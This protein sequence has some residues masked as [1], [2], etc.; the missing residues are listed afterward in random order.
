MSKGAVLNCTRWVMGV[1]PPPPGNVREGMGFLEYRDKTRQERQTCGV[2]P[3][4]NHW[5]T[6]EP[7]LCLLLIHYVQQ[8]TLQKYTFSSKGTATNLILPVLATTQRPE[9]LLFRTPQSQGHSIGY[10]SHYLSCPYTLRWRSMTA[11]QLMT[12]LRVVVPL[13]GEIRGEF[14]SLG[15]SIILI[16]SYRNH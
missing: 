16:L 1:L 11:W 14:I 8:T 9:T 13:S 7:H 2:N 15:Y 10:S 3:C 4:P 6:F 5:E 12:F